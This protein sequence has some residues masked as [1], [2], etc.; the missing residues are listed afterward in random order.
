MTVSGGQLILHNDRQVGIY[1]MDGSE[2][3]SGAIEE[4]MIQSICKTGSNRYMVVMEEGLE[5]IRLK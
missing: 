4:G 5:T 2:K 3:F 1:G